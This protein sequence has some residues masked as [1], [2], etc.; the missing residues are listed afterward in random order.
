MPFRL[1]T[2][3]FLLE[4][5]RTVIYNRRVKYKNSE[6]TVLSETQHIQE[7]PL[8]QIGISNEVVRAFDR[9]GFLH[10]TGIQQK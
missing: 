4:T 1:K 8:A 6:D 2:P 9:M 10:L 5:L 7:H 3:A